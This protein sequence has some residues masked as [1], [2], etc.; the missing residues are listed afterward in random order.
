MEENLV[1]ARKESTKLY[2]RPDDEN[3]SLVGF[4]PQTHIS[5]KRFVMLTNSGYF[6]GLSL[7]RRDKAKHSS[8]TPAFSFQGL[9]DEYGIIDLI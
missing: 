3:S 2:G 1:K 9:K 7:R 8:A 4:V 6:F 5:D